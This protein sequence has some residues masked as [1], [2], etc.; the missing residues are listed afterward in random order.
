MDKFETCQ[1]C[2]DRTV[3]PNCHMTCEG[4]MFRCEQNKKKRSLRRSDSDYE[5]FKRERVRET[6][7]K[8]NLTRW[9]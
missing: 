8:L 3:E 4:Y 2:E 9:K 1:G 5:T 7:K 6:K